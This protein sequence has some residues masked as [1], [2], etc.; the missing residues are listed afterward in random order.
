MGEIFLIAFLVFVA[1]AIIMVKMGIG[2]WINLGWKA[3]FLISFAMG[4]IFIGTFTGMAIG[5]V[6]G[7]FTSIFLSC[8]KWVYG[9][10]TKAKTK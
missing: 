3:D 8:A 9:P 4:F 10:T 1:F 5:I 7:V 6:A 2:K